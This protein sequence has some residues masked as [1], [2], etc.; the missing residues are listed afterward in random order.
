MYPALCNK[1]AVHW[2]GSHKDDVIQ[3]SGFKQDFES[4]KVRISKL[5]EAAVKPEEKPIEKV[6]EKAG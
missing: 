3:V 5:E 1:Q 4:L 2:D 6:V